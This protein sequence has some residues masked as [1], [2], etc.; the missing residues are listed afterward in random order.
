MSE[1]KHL[2]YSQINTY[3]TCG[4]RYYFRYVLGKK[5][6]P[7]WT[8]ALGKSC[9]ESLSYNYKQK[10]QTK[11][12]LPLKEILE[13]YDFAF[14]V[15]RQQEVDWQD[16]KPGV[17][18]DIGVKL[19]SLYHK[20]RC[21]LVQPIA[22]QDKVE[23]YFENVDYYFIAYPDLIDSKKT[24]VDLKTTSRTPNG[25]EAITSEQ[26]TA[27]S[28]AYRV[29]YGKPE[30]GVRLEYLVNIKEPKI[31]LLEAKRTSEE[32]DHFLETVARVAEGIE[33]EVFV[34]T[35]ENSIFCNPRS[36]GYYQLCRPNKTVISLAKIQ[37][38]VKNE[39]KRSKGI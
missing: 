19:V 28:L 35:S 18:K 16:K 14:E 33:K 1:I 29:K 36:C 24:I 31:V 10:I 8:F 5:I 3:R 38:E 27:Y 23:I 12:D 17:V 15:Q 13:A 9:D 37:K 4:M 25:R 32:I 20:E 26:L 6:P 39:A 21:P 30:A 22:V 7:P 2:S 11:K 34:P